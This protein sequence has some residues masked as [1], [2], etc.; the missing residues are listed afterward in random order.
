MSEV[1]L[2]AWEFNDLLNLLFKCFR[3]GKELGVAFWNSEDTSFSC[4]IREVAEWEKRNIVEI[5]SLQRGLVWAPHQVELLW[6]SILRGFPIGAFTLTPVNGNEGQLT[7]A[8]ESK[9][10]YFLLDGQQRYNAI[11]AAF[12]PWDNEAKSVLWVDFMPPSQTNSTRRFW[13]KVITKAHPWG[14]EN[15]DTCSVLGWA[16]YRE[17]LKRFTG[18]EDTRI[19]DV[20][21]STAWPFKARCPVPFYFVIEAFSKCSGDDAVFY[22][23]IVEWCNSHSKVGI[24]EKN[25]DLV[26]KTAK[27]MF[28][29][30]VRMS[31]YP[32]F[33]N[34]LQA[35]M[36]DEHDAVGEN[37]PEDEGTN[38]LE[39]LFT[40]INTLGTP[41]SPYDL[42]YSAIKA[43]WGDIKEANDNIAGTIM[44]AAHLA[45][46]SFRLALTLASDRI[47][48]A[49]TPSVQRIRSLKK[50]D[51][52]VCGFVEKLYAN[53][54]IM[55]RNIIERVETAL[56][57]YKREGDPEDGL[58][59]VI[60]TSIIL[61]SPDIF[62]LLLYM[63]H[64]GKLDDF[65]NL[66]GLATWLHWFSRVQQKYIVDAIK[67]IV[68]NGDLAALKTRLRELCQQNALI[69][70]I[71]ASEETFLLPSNF[72]S[73]DHKSFD[74]TRFENEPWFPV[75]T[76]I[77]GLRDL[78][79]FATRRLFNKEFQYNPAET[80]FL[81]GHNRPWDMDHIIPKS[82]VSLQ[83]VKMGPFKEV[84][85][86]WIWCIGNFA[87]IPFTL[88]RSKSNRSDWHYY[89]EHKVELFF[90][91]E[92]E[93]LQ[94]KTMTEDEKMAM[95]FIQ[96]TH[97]RM[98]EMYNEWRKQILEFL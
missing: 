97:T 17:A 57:V 66:A 41:I 72:L 5:P 4:P 6:D 89:E 51:A 56:R 83:R 60:R 3:R 10:K 34:I 90:Q 67:E 81:T 76:R 49:D 79:I 96:A 40:R 24:K 36:L 25:S 82:W 98:I 50:N 23:G 39:Q 84:C 73:H 75:F 19:Q 61:N 95:V 7:H 43:Y 26:A 47:G 9:A 69:D 14:F 16:T 33:A 54:G 28:A 58:P 21:M 62:L 46:L 74:Q 30:L 94:S 88:N 22:E 65:G 29:A 18:S 45:I 20:K 53:D 64:K 59:A 12:T 13:I 91:D 38:S 37:N 92:V 31:K 80:I 44:P 78:V 42:R 1:C 71:E 93:D 70:P 87:A 27:S 86:K 35:E 11:K 8:S 55:L 68:D 48:F 77:W 85:E 63:A 32:V 52:A 15:N 2:G